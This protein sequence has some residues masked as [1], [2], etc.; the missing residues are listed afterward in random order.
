MGINMIELKNKEQ[1][2][3]YKFEGFIDESNSFGNKPDDYE[4]FQ[5]LGEGAFGCVLKV[6]KKWFWYIYNEK[7]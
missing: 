2:F 1:I 6:K 3:E 7:G 5:K 4:V